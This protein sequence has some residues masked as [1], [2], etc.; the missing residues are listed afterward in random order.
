MDLTE[1]RG[2]DIVF[3]SVGGEV[4]EKSM[5]CLSSYGKLITYGHASGKPGQILSTNLHST[6]RSVIG[7]SPGERQHDYPESLRESAETVMTLLSTEEL[8]VKISEKL[9]LEEVNKGFQLMADR[10][11]IGK[12]L[13]NLN[14]S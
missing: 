13:I 14:D 4:L 6:S 9:S 11:N 2:V 5:K 8:D 7:Y 1:R 3:D 12:I 10:G